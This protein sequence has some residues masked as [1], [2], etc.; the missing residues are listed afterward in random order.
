MIMRDNDRR[1][2][3][4]QREL[5]ERDEH[6]SRLKREI[7]RLETERDSRPVGMVRETQTSR[8]V[9][10]SADELRTLARFVRARFPAFGPHARQSEDD[11]AREFAA[12][13][14]ALAYLNRIETP[15]RKKA[16]SYWIDVC[17]GWLRARNMDDVSITTAPFMAAVIAHDIPWSTDRSLGLAEGVGRPCTNA[18]L[19]V[20][21][22]GELREPIAAAEAPRDARPQQLLLRPTD[23]PWCPGRVDRADIW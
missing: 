15:D 11:Y 22:T 5:A 19:R 7:A 8:F 13:F 14:R 17:R 23:E 3:E 21:E 1:V 12:A 2:D 18:W 6:I 10:P 9:M 4:L 20:L 16:L